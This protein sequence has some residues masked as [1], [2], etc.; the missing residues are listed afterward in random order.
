[1][2]VLALTQFCQDCELVIDFYKD[3]TT[4]IKF[5]TRI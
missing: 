2:V 5:K 1:M 4:T 3:A